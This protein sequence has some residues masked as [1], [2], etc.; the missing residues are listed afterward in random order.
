[1]TE[2][3]AGEVCAKY[4]LTVCRTWRS[5]I[6]GVLYLWLVDEARTSIRFVR[7][8]HIHELVDLLTEQLAIDTRIRFGNK[9]NGK[10]KNKN[11]STLL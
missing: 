9:L 11:G 1:M 3:D 2:R 7:A 10:G 5:S 6:S 8:E 4:G